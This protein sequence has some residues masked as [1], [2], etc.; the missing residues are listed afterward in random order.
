MICYTCRPDRYIKSWCKITDG[1]KR[2][3]RFGHIWACL[4][5]KRYKKA[6][7]GTFGQNWDDLGGIGQF[8]DELVRI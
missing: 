1:E 7:L 3:F 5:T 4:G 2:G 6:A 8:W